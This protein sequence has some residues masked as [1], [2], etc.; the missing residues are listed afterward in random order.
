MRR[1]IRLHHAPIGHRTSLNALRTNGETSLSG[2][3]ARYSVV[4]MADVGLQAGVHKMV[5]GSIG[6]AHRTY[7]IGS[8]TVPTITRARAGRPWD[9][10]ATSFAPVAR[11]GASPS[12][13]TRPS[14]LPSGP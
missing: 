11:S 10:N 2:S 9:E 4:R 13:A 6:R 5:A 3:H 1:E 8:P 14:T 12:G 7:V